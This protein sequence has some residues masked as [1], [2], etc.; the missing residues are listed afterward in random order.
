MSQPNYSKILEALFTPDILE[1]VAAVLEL[2]GQHN[3][4]Q[5]L[6]PEHLSGLVKVARIQSTKASNKLENIQ[7]TD[8]K[9]EDLMAKKIEP[10]TRAESEIAGYRFVLD[11]IH[12]EHEY[13]KVTPSVI[14]QLHRDLYRYEKTHFAG[15]WK[16]LDNKIA[17]VLESREEVTRFIPTSAV[18]TPEAVAQIC[19]EFK[20][21]S[22]R[23]KIE[24]LL[25]SLVFSFDF[26]SIHPFQD[27]NG[28]MSRLLLLLLLYKSGIQVGKYV[29]IEK[30]IE[31]SKE[32]YYEVLRSSSAG[33]HEGESDYGPYVRYLLGV[34]ISCYKE[35]ESRFV[36][37]S[38]AFT[39][40]EAIRAYFDSLVGPI[41]KRDIRYA[42]PQMSQKTI[43]RILAKL[44]AEGVIQK[45]GAARS[46]EYLRVIDF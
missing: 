45:V 8:K 32:S 19:D 26:V 5:E 21:V 34:I 28:R 23:G 37:V 36:R 24:A 12:S 6:A 30:E 33:W 43:E 11:L 41:R 20:K 22:K 46:T 35:L 31:A 15:N 44:Q 16:K 27:G 2:Q 18:F 3:V 29:S 9:L 39:N 14:L 10:Q 25:S 13:I 17:E 42:H 38:A 7:T 4:Y 1:Q 40:E